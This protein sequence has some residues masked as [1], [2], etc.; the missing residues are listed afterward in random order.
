MARIAPHPPPPHHYRASAID[1]LQA[2]LQQARDD[3]QYINLMSR[4]YGKVN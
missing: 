2:E 1:E 4:Q 3:A